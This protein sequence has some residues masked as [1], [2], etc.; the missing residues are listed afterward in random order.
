M[1]N[2]GDRATEAL[3]Y[4]FSETHLM[5]GAQICYLQNITSCLTPISGDGN[6]TF[7]KAFILLTYEFTCFAADFPRDCGFNMA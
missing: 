5:L 1:L 7:F 4:V 6:S 3:M 2:N